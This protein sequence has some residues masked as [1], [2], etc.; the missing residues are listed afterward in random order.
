MTALWICVYILLVLLSICVVIFVVYSGYIGYV[1]WKYAHLPGPP[2]D[3]FWL[4]NLPQLKRM[5]KQG[6]YTHTLFLKWAEEYGPLF[7]IFV[8]HKCM[9]VPTSRTAIKEILTKSKV[10][11]KSS[12]TYDRL[13]S[14][15]GTRFLGRGLVTNTNHIDWS[16]RRASINPSFHKKS[17]VVAMDQFNQEIDD[18]MDT[19]VPLADGITKFSMAEKINRV[20]LDIIGKV[21]FNMALGC[22]SDE[23][24]PYPAA[25]DIILEG[26]SLQ[27]KDPIL[28]WRRDKQTFIS[29]VKQAVGLLR[30]AF[31]KT[32]EDRIG[33][34]NAGK[35][36]PNDTLQYLLKGLE[37]NRSL[38]IEDLLDDFATL[39]VAGQET[40]SHTLAFLLN[41]VGRRPELLHRLVDEVDQVLGDRTRVTFEDT[42]RL[43]YMTQVF[44]ET[45]RL[46]PPAPGTARENVTDVSLEGYNIPPRS[47][48]VISFFVI[49]RLKRHH[50]DPEDFDP[51]RF[52]DD[53]PRPLFTFMPFSTGQ[54]SC[55]GKRFAQLECKVL[56]CKFL[57]RFTYSLDP[58]QSFDIEEQGSL[59]PRG[60]AIMTLR[61]RL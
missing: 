60:G 13:Y 34:M 46:Y 24:S 32:I 12:V 1:H 11:P 55:V 23:T 38:T 50:N 28:M 42:E 5:H 15:C 18:W 6:V 45:L 22:V 35:D 43:T 61:R 29:E 19:L 16:T 9:V 17:L 7:R 39:F 20:T 47:F 4:G 52:A 31:Q 26:T 51:D 40:I 58:D 41:E 8:L 10:Y 33:A 30:K 27:M 44:K 59:R 49:H 2:I 57:K 3:S 21:A 56:L 25:M 36:V 14:V 53:K 54:R 37:I 48:L